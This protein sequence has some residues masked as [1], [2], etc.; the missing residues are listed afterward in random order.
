MGR[1]LAPHSEISPFS[2]IVIRH[3]TLDSLENC[4]LSFLPSVCTCTEVR[5]PKPNWSVWV[6]KFTLEMMGWEQ[7]EF[8]GTSLR[9]SKASV[10]KGAEPFCRT[11]WRW[12]CFF[13]APEVWRK[14]LKGV[15]VGSDGF[16]I[17]WVFRD[18][19]LRFTFWSILQNKSISHL[20][21]MKNLHKP[22]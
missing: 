4:C 19:Q 17:T 15:I 3:L 2:L 5:A 14:K 20:L 22:S 10:P 8:R 12:E 13:M 1:P 21:K 16:L 6:E 9:L 18:S 7:S 11:P